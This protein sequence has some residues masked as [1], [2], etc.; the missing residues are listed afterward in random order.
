M[1]AAPS[2]AYQLLT[3]KDPVAS[4]KVLGAIVASL[5]LLKINVVNHLFHLAYIGLL[6]SAAAEYS[7][8]LATGQGFVTK[9]LGKPKSQ[10]SVLRESVL[11]SLANLAETLESR[12]HQ[13][14]YAQDIE[15]TL[16]TAGVS[17]IL[18]KLT[19]WFSLYSLVFAS[20]VLAFSVPVVYQK[21]KKEIDAA[22]AH[23]TKLAK[24]KAAPVL[25]AVAKKTGPIG[26]FI[27][28]KFP[29]RTAGSTVGTSSV[30][31]PSTGYTSGASQFPKVPATNPSV[32]EVV[33]DATEKVPE[34]SL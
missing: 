4:G 34:P 6:I 30:E 24:E 10:S 18:F 2:S 15:A 7:G 11:P 32:S 23:Y 8:K 14:V 29:T 3:W 16:R 33:E 9:Y 21:N 19:S 13:V 28:T 22:V 20:V 26:S 25:D 17:Y 12:F 31:E 27:Q 5:L 1:S